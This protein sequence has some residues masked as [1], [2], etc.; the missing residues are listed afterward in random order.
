MKYSVSYSKQA[1]KQIKKLDNYTRIMIIRWIE[2]NLV[3][4][5]NP[6]ENGKALKGKLGDYWRYRVGDYR[7]IS[8]I[9]DDELIIFVVEIG[10]RREVYK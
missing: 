9:E 5:I 3:G 1:Q 4:S 2:K 10:H 7:I 8:K 6:R